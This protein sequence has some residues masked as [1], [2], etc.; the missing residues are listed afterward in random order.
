[1]PWT[2]RSRNVL[3]ILESHMET[4]TGSRERQMPKALG[5]VSISKSR[6]SP[7]LPSLKYPRVNYPHD[8]SS[9]SAVFSLSL[10]ALWDSDD[11]CSHQRWAEGE[12]QTSQAASWWHVWAEKE[13]EVAA[14]VETLSFSCY[15]PSHFLMCIRLFYTSGPLFMVLLL[16]PL[17]SHRV[18]ILGSRPRSYLLPKAVSDVPSL[19]Y[20]ASTLFPLCQKKK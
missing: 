1:M 14:L 18:S 2:Q 17:P 13:V 19:S 4:W 15:H 5:S 8:V 3:F 9:K 6:F 7:W 20:L 16:S 11:Y 10:V 12:A